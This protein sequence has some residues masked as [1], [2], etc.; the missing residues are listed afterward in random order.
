[1]DA[2][3][4]REL[5]APAVMIPACGLL[6]LSTNA[7]MM[8]VIQRIRALHHERLLAYVDDPGEHARRK[9]ARQIRLDGL[10]WQTDH[11]LRRLEKM[12]LTMILLFASIIAFVVSSGLIGLAAI[13]P[14]FGSGAVGTFAL[15][16]LLVIVAMAVS[17]VEM[18][19]GLGAVR[20]EHER[21][22]R[23]DPDNGEGGAA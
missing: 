16:G 7:R 21:I 12:R 1:M 3:I 9:K 20:Y 22:A 23:L 11:M 15:A 2:D 5:V 4:I 6:C 14:A 17:I 10:T 13:W 18:W 8:S 19:A